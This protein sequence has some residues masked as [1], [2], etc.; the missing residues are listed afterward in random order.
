MFKRWK[1]FALALAAVLAAAVQAKGELPEIAGCLVMV[2][3]PTLALIVI[4][5]GCLWYLGTTIRRDHRTARE[6]RIKE[7]WRAVVDAFY[8]AC[9]EY[10][11][12]PA[13]R[14]LDS[15]LRAH[16]EALRVKSVR[17]QESKE[18]DADATA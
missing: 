13:L 5:L 17:P 10:P 1:G 8:K 11:T 7:T 2:S 3:W 16:S 9:D 18:D 6:T 14:G 15:P 12:A 4:A